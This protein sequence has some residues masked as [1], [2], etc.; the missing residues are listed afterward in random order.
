MP[1][2]KT[3]LA[4]IL[5]VAN[6]TVTGAMAA[7]RIS[8][9]TTSLKSVHYTYAVSAAKAINTYSGDNVAV[10][11]ISTGGAVDNL[12]RLS[13]GQIKMG[14]GTYST[15][16]QAYKGIGKF[17]GKPQSKLRGLWVYATALQAWVVRKDS[18]IKTLS[19]LDGK[20]FT[21]GQRGS[22]T[23]QL[24]IQMLEALNITPDLY[25]TSLSDAI[26]AVK[27][28][29]SSGYV[30]AGGA[31]AL[32]GTTLE[33]RSFTPIRVLSFNPDQVRAV[34][35]RFP[36]IRF[37]TLK[38]D[39]IEGI[40]ETTSPMQVI[41]QFAYNDSLTDDQVVA[42]LTGIIDGK[43]IQEAA[44]PDIKK[45]D[46]IQTSLEMMTIPLHAGAVKFYRSRGAVVPDHLIPPEMK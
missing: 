36:F 4:G 2:H 22:A 30:K 18:D 38:Q 43:K 14:L 13:R 5:F 6:V 31:A 10:T 28:N 33:L 29:R 12:K 35:D 46:I 45:I 17:E 27:D 42:I 24:V 1:N 23:E 41:G 9:G 16:Y 39:E 44:F 34:N 21:P 32:D 15:I 37:T 11:V 20:K 19:E 8:Y 26:A 3:F 25:R 7:D 40:P